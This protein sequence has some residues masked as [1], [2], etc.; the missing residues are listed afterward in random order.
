[1]TLEDADEGALLT[2]VHSNVPDEQTGYERGGWA[3]YYFEPM[4]AISPD[5]GQGCCWEGKGYPAQDKG[6]QDQAQARDHEGA[7]KAKR[8]TATAA[9]AASVKKKPK[10]A[11]VIAK[12]KVKAPNGNKRR[13][14]RGAKRR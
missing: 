5:Q 10:K 1:M 12:A 11:R 8:R 7:A 14:S 2:L 9:K 6:C 13:P 4:K 3:E